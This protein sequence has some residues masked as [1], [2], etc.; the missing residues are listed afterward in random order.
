MHVGLIFRISIEVGG[1][2]VYDIDFVIRKRRTWRTDIAEIAPPVRPSVFPGSYCDTRL[3]SIK[4]SVETFYLGRVSAQ[5]H[6][7]W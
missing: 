4:D 5:R 2:D 3:Y 6:L 1:I 7:S